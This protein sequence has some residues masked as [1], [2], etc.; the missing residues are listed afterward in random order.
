MTES[1]V[2]SLGPGAPF[3]CYTLA[4]RLHFFYME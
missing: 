2:S 3:N 1:S 4:A